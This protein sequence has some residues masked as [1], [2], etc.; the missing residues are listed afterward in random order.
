MPKYTV[1]EKQL[2]HARFTHQIFAFTFSLVWCEDADRLERVLR[3]NSVEDI[4]PVCR[5]G[6]SCY[7]LKTSHGIEPTIAYPT[8]W[9][10]SDPQLIALLAHECI[11]AVMCMFRMKS[12]P[13]PKN[14]SF[15]DADE[16]HFCY[17]H[18]WLLQ[19][20]LFAM[21]E[22]DKHKIQFDQEK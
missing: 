12:I 7:F 1:N 9:K 17:T 14:G 2:Y 22:Q 20:C 3:I 19:E 8:K 13:L 6:A 16:E 4:D 18:Q 11:H 15:R 21:K 5:I 10:S